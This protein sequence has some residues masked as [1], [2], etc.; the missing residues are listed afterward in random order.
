LLGRPVVE[1]VNQKAFE[2]V[3][4]GLTALAVVKL[5]VF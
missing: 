2:N 3:V 5:L 1:R 4:L